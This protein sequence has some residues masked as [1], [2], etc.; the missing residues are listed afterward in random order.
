[1]MNSRIPICVLMLTCMMQVSADEATDIETLP[2]LDI[3]ARPI[4]L[5]SIEHI[6]QPITIL[7]GEEL[8]KKQ[9]STI[10]ETLENIPGVSTDRFSPLAS[11]PVI[12]GLGGPRVQVLENGIGSLDAST[13]SVDHIV[14]IDPLQA[15]QI[16]IFR[17]PA[18]LLY[19]S[20]AA[21]GFINVVTNRIPDN[22]PDS[23]KPKIYSSYNTNSLE[24]VIALQGDG[25]YEK[26]AFHIDAVNRDAKN[27]ESASGVVGNSYYDQ[28]NVNFGTSYVDDWGYLGISYG[29]LDSTHGV[30]V[31]PEEPDELKFLDSEQDR[32]DVNAELD[33]DTS[34]LKAL[35]FQMGYN[36][37][38]HTE[39]ESPTETGTIFNNEQLQGRIELQHQQ[40]G[41]FNG[42]IGTQF[43]YRD[44]TAV[45]EEAFIPKTNTDNF[46]IFVLEDTDIIE[47]VHFEIGGR[48]EYVSSNPENANDV[49][50]DLFS[51]STGIH[52]HFREDVALGLTLGRSQRAPVTEELFANGP[53]EATSTFEIGDAGLDEETAYSVDLTLTKETGRWQWNASLFANY[54]ED[55]IFLQGLDRNND[56]VV[57]EVDDDGV[58]PGELLLVQYQQ[59]DSRFYGF[60]FASKFNLF[61]NQNG[62]LDWNL[63]TDYV[64]AKRT[65]GE[66]LPRISP[67]RIGT[68]LDYT[69][70]RFRAGIDLTSVLAQNDNGVL[71]TDTGGYTLL[72]LNANYTLVTG[73]QT[74]DVFMRA[75]NLLDEDG[76]LHTSFIKDRAPIMGQS[77]MVGFEAGF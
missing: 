8:R 50:N 46:A 74:L 51:I 6:A 58:S 32:F 4:G 73:E 59:G 33:L 39:F 30:P 61:N 68:G 72:N 12:R 64:R 42:V 66:N 25:G 70:N 49:S 19:G 14:S 1:M 24:K 45:G 38:D 54:I 43:G 71:E 9:S 65:N 37:Y 55:F 13:I 10:G 77:L 5:Q 11:R 48:Y 69:L 28:T 23:F 7:K 52:W 67:A 15:E 17:G 3:Y 31:N 56:G 26:F 63:F 35:R 75:N 36:D 62:S 40:L 21:G 60:E 29:R 22:V 18:T 16:E 20:E 44:V 34:L 57:D 41:V 47:N 27:Y 76:E 2:D 53:H